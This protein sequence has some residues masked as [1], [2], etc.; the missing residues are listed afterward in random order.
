MIDS[1]SIV[2]IGMDELIS[3]HLKGFLDDKLYQWLKLREINNTDD[4]KSLINELIYICECS[5]K[6]FAMTRLGTP[7]SARE[8]KVALDRTFSSWDLFIKKL[9]KE[10]WFLVD[11]LDKYSYKVLF[12]ENLDFKKVYDTL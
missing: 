9:Q 5:W 11:T 10:K 4:F 7:Q 8:V 2:N 3:I 12:M 1:K 6:P